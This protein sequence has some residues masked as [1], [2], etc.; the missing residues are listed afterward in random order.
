MTLDTPDM[1][2]HSLY[3]SLF[4]YLGSVTRR[5]ADGAP[6]GWDVNTSP[7]SLQH[8]ADVLDGFQ[9]ETAG[10]AT[11]CGASATI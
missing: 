8:R 2:I 3:F 5:S 11:R 10:Q 4:S 9:N 1:L 7:L 6:S